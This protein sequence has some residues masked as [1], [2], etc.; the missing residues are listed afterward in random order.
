M[1]FAQHGLL[2]VFA[3]KGVMDCR[4]NHRKSALHG[5]LWSMNTLFLVVPQYHFADMR[6]KECLVLASYGVWYILSTDVACEAS[7]RCQ[8]FHSKER[9]NGNKVKSCESSPFGTKVD[10]HFNNSVKVKMVS[11]NDVFTV[12]TYFNDSQG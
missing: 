9:R 2:T 5:I 12:P 1:I 10:K 4:N 8:V 11:E 6:L 3:Q 7:Y